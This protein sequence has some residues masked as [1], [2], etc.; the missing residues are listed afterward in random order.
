MSIEH[1]IMFQKDVNDYFRQVPEEDFL[2]YNGSLVIDI[3][4]NYPLYADVS[5]FDTWIVKVGT[6]IITHSD[7]RRMHY[8]M[9]CISEE[10]KWLKHNGKNVLLVTSGA[11]GLGRKLRQR[12]GEIIPEEEKD[13]PKQ[14]QRDSEF[15]QPL[16]YAL[17]ESNL[18]FY[19]Q[20]AVESLVV[21]EDFA[22]NRE[23]AKLMSSYKGFLS[24]GFIPVIN[25]DDKRTLAEIETE[26]KGEKM[27][28]DNDGLSSLIAQYLSIDGHKVILT[29]LTD[30]DGIL[31]TD[32]L[33]KSINEPIRI[34]GNFDGI[35]KYVLA[36]K[37]GK[38]RGGMLSKIDAASKAK[39]SGAYVVIANGMYCN[40]DGNYQRGCGERKFYPIRA[41]A[42]GKVVGTRCLPNGY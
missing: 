3:P 39:S 32:E 42:E 11:I 41:I 30:T 20:R 2:M 37:S 12:Y 10:L 29:M 28:R 33:K 21:N 31:A 5:N 6:N 4:E 19:S 22:N 24:D 13:L 38:T 27:F 7:R 16:L 18:S 40:H 15:G 14:K 34:V 35:E 26:L 17:W 8:T 9:R 1:R 23:K 25:E 36:E